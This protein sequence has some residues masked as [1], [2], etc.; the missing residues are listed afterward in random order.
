MATLLY[1]EGI[2][3][4]FSGM[5]GSIGPPK[6]SRHCKSIRT[7]A[8]LTDYL[9]TMMKHFYPGRRSLFQF[10]S[11]PIHRAWDVNDVNHMP[12]PSE[13]RDLNK[14]LLYGGFL[15]DVLNRAF[16][17][18]NQNPKWGKIFWRNDAHCFHSTLPETCRIN[19]MVQWSCSG[20][21]FALIWY[22]AKPVIVLWLLIDYEY[23]VMCV[24]VCVFIVA[25]IM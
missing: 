6:T 5:S 24:R 4:L 8:L 7:A 20:T 19:A 10:D 3:L 2:S 23:V 25:K 14:Q 1:F 22:L 15:S 18:L 9:Y 11:A 17:H 16:H 21:L 12:Q 13:S